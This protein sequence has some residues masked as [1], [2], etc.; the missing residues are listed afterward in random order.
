MSNFDSNGNYNK[1]EWKDDD[2]ITA[3]KLN[4][5]EDAI[6]TINEND[7]SR[8]KET[9][10]R[11][12]ELEEKNKAIEEELNN[13]ANKEHT[14]D[15]Y[16]TEHQDLS[17]YA[18]KS[19]IPKDYL[20]E[21]PNEYVTET[22]LNN[23]GYL[24]EH[25]DISHLATKEELNQGKADM[26]AMVSEV[27]G[28]LEG[29]KNNHL[30]LSVKD[31]GAKGDGVTDDTNAILNAI[32]KAINSNVRA[33]FIPS[34][35]YII[36]QSI[37][38]TSPIRITGNGIGES[39][40][41]TAIVK[42]GDF[43]GI[44]IHSRDVVLENFSVK[45]R[46][47]VD[48]SDGIIVGD[49]GYNAQSC[50][51]KNVILHQNGGNGITLRQC[52]NGVFDNIITLYN[53]ASGFNTHATTEANY[54]GNIINI[55]NSYGNG[56]CGAVISGEGN[57]FYICAQSNTE[58]NIRIIG[59][60]N[61]C[62]I[63]GYTEFAKTGYEINATGNVFANNIKGTFRSNTNKVYTSKT[64]LPNRL[65]FS[66]DLQNNDM[67]SSTIDNKFMAD[68][69]Y[70]LSNM[71]ATPIEHNGYLKYMNTGVN[72]IDRNDN[73]HIIAYA[74]HE[75]LAFNNIVCT[76]VDSTGN[77]FLNDST[78]GFDSEYRI[79]EDGVIYAICSTLKD[80]LTADILQVFLYK[81]GKEVPNAYV[82]YSSSSGI[83]L[84]KNISVAVV[85]G[86]LISIKA[87]WYSAVQPQNN[88]LKVVLYKK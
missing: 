73:A 5:I 47:N 65:S 80:A 75:K 70:F 83:Y 58:D 31:F 37:I 27:E 63:M 74:S 11:L 18:L 82:Q 16:L 34:G 3:D 72:Y 19:E 71:N 77:V 78:G 79:F 17:D 87:V 26:E 7:K 84:E 49:E 68:G 64:G 59:W 2:L 22:E 53:G 38:I 60:C 10:N 9:D 42:N 1:T 4:K 50:V 69:F 33:V 25:Q 61:N 81:N 46:K 86:D 29:V 13:K 55:T 41:P 66:T 39:F 67:S 6:Q 54:S 51:I 48:T 14:H 8:Y 30:S 32:N 44:V 85:K 62:D 15:E 12:D 43:P 40:T 76:P 28:E 20:T 52:N 21:I 45:G 36:S 24:T 88:K 23:K 35:V 56:V 57:K